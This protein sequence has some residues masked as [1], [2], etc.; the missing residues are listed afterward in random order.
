MINS[1]NI[2]RIVILGHNG[3]IGSHLTE[4]FKAEY[5]EIEFIGKSMPEVD[6]TRAE[7]AKNMSSCFDMDTAVIM[8][9]AIKRQFADDQESF[10]KNVK[11]VMN[12]C[13]LLVSHPVRRFI[14]F[15]SASV[16]GEDIHNAR[17]TEDTPVC[18]TSYYGIAKYTCERLLMKNF[19]T[20]NKG[21]LFIM[22]PPLVYGPKDTG[23]TYGPAG[24]IKAALSNKK[25]TLWGDGAELREF[26]FVDDIVRVVKRLAFS[27]LTDI[28]N[29]ASGK[30]VSFKD[31]LDIISRLTGNVLTVDSRK[32]T[33]DK[34]DNKFSNDKFV[35]L[36][37]DFSFTSFEEGIKKTIQFERQ[38]VAVCQD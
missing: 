3:F 38:D 19:A 34:V 26:I 1:N 21:S 17:I 14:F 29:I 20:T 18:P 22:R 11:I 16:Y 28:V 33:K 36:F 30:S 4:S 15:S 27:S 25:I 31:I 24:F 6:L 7:D 32:R 12:L 10:D 2:K 35:K 8:C 23:S 37:N 9:A 5:P 13:D